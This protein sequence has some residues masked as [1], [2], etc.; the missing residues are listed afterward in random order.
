M[1]ESHGSRDAELVEGENIAALNLM[2]TS[3]TPKSKNNELPERG[4]WSSKV[5]FILSVV[6]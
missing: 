4:T 1:A 3:T 2:C 6:S 5:D